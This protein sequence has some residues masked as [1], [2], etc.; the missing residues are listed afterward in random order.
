M[1]IRMSSTEWEHWMSTERESWKGQRET[2]NKKL[3]DTLASIALTSSSISSLLT[4][5]ATK[6]APMKAE[7]ADQT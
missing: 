7:T 3:A 2:F 6:G 1:D 5:S 4:S